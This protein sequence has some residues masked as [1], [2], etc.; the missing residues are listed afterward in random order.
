MEYLNVSYTHT[1]TDGKSTAVLD[2]FILTPRL[3]SLVKRCGVVERGDNQSRHCPIW[4]ELELGAIPVKIKSRQWIPKRPDWCN[5][6]AQDISAYRESLEE[7][8]RSIENSADGSFKC[9]KLH[10]K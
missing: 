9:E 5:A 3:L 2:H 4:V 8:L 1:H 6:D 10:C 7:K